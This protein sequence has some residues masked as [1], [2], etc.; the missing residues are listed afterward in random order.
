MEDEF[1]LQQLKCH[2]HFNFDKKLRLLLQ[3]QWY[4]QHFTLGYSQ[5]SAS[6]V[7]NEIAHIYL[8]RDMA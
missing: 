7:E 1:M 2:I 3:A 5:N 8:E 4:T 6:P